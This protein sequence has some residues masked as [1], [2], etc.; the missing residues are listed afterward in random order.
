VI[1]WNVFFAKQL[2]PTTLVWGTPAA[3]RWLTVP[4]ELH[5]LAMPAP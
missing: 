4:F 1:S 3:T 5:D 2:K